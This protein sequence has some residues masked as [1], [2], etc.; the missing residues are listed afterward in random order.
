MNSETPY[1]P[2]KGFWDKK[3]PWCQPWSI[4][5]TGIISPLLS[6]ILLHNIWIVSS[7]IVL[8]LLWWWLF[9]FIAPSSYDDISLVKNESDQ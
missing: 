7:L 8:V 2:K 3:P 5:L 4:V 9:L 1:S 6:W